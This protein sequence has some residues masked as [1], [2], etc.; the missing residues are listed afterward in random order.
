[1]YA[2][3][4]DEI[5]GAN[6]G[7]F[8]ESAAKWRRTRM[9]KDS[10]FSTIANR[11][12]LPA[13]SGA[14]PTLCSVC[15]TALLVDAIPVETVSVIQGRLRRDLRVARVAVEGCRQAGQCVQ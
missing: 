8:V 2:G 10:G 5:V 1:M 6:T 15:P 9:A 4:S 12:R 13:T 11:R 3:A 14:G 7:L